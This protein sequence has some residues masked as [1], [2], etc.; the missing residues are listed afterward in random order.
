MTPEQLQWLKD[1]AAAATEAQHVFPEMAACEAALES[2]YGKSTLSQEAF[3]LFG[4]K[5]H[6][7]PLYETIALPTKEYLDGKWAP[8]T[9]DWVKYPDLK[10]CF[11][12]RMATLTRLAPEPKYESY[13]RAL[14]APTPQTYVEWVSK[15]WSTDPDRA[16]NA[17]KI[18]A[19][20]KASTLPPPDLT[21]SADL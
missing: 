19:T 7:H 6:V 15:S 3:N 13:R 1:T 10:S 8:T 17:C 11:V 5:Q 2:G 14:M 18:Y 12:D 9:S 4:M 21:D 16:V 20:L